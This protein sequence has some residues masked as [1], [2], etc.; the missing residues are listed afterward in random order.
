MPCPRFLVALLVVHIVVVFSP[1]SS[2][3][4]TRKRICRVDG[5]HDSACARCASTS[6]TRFTLNVIVRYVVIYCFYFIR[7]FVSFLY[8]H[9]VGGDAVLFAA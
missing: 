5:F 8:P 6:R 7:A 1:L 9:G 4:V 2:S 3:Y